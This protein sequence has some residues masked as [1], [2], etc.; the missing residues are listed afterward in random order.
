M[1]LRH[2][3]AQ[4]DYVQ[5]SLQRTLNMLRYKVM[6]SSVLEYELPSYIDESKN[7]HQQNWGYENTLGMNIMLSAA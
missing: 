6:V 2:A 4:N 1:S 3:P 5:Y 7:L